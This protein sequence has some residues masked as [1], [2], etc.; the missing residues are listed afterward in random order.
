MDCLKA[1]FHEDKN[2]NDGLNP[3]SLVCRKYYYNLNQ[4]RFKIHQKKYNEQ[5]TGKRNLYAKNRRKIDVIFRLIVNTTRRI[6]HVLKEKI[7]SSSAVDV[8][9]LDI[10]TFRNWVEYQ[11]TPEMN[12]S[13]IK[14][15]HVKP[16]SSLDV[17]KED[18]LRE[19]LNWSNIQ[20]LIKELESQKGIKFIFVSLSMTV[21]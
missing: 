9:W 6:H 12:W 11:F 18:E 8:L 16:I 4:N 19:T 7:L 13:N 21:Y 14:I 5:L 15:D 20:T 3:K 17:S 1:N 2:K 10:D